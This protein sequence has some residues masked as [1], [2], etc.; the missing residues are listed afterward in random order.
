MIP[1]L[2]KSARTGHPH[3]A[4]CQRTKAWPPRPTRRDI[5]AEFNA[6][7]LAASWPPSPRAR[8]R[9]THCVGCADNSKARATR[10]RHL[11]GW[12]TG[13]PVLPRTHF[14]SIGLRHGSNYCPDPSRV[15]AICREGTER[16]ACSAP[17]ALARTGGLGG[18]FG[19][20]VEC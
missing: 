3:C 19:G 4:D 2:A 5:P 17:N 11:K 12:A 8:G 15:R 20:F 1:A 13:P 9:G 16:A 18:S 14:A 10:P 7:L 6:A